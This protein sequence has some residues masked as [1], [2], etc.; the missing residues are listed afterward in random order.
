MWICDKEHIDNEVTTITA[1]MS[2]TN[3]LPVIANQ[4]QQSASIYCLFALIQ[5][6][7]SNA[8]MMFI[9]SFKPQKFVIQSSKSINLL[10]YF[11]TLYV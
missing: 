11:T 5:M 10:H 2:A 9:I 3:A 7:T 4:H 1:T 6:K 8:F